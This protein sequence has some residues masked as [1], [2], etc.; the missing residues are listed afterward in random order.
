MIGPFPLRVHSSA[1]SAA[2][3]TAMEREPRI[4]AGRQMDV[5]IA[6]VVAKHDVVSRL[7]RL[8]QLRFQQQRLGFG[9][10]DRRLDASDLRDHRGEARV[11]LRLEEIIADALPEIAR[12]ADVEQLVVRAEHAVDAGRAG[13]RADESLAVEG[14]LGL[15]TG[16]ADIMVGR[17]RGFA[18]TRGEKGTP[19]SPRTRGPSDF[20]FCVVWEE[21][22]AASP[23]SRGRR[24]SRASPAPSP[25]RRRSSLADADVLRGPVRKIDPHDL[26][27][28]P[29]RDPERTRRER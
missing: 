12:L 27:Q 19:S 3:R 9:A 5:R 8:D 25:G 1:T 26:V 13:Q 10:R 11:H 16:H 21:E 24:K 18:R 17:A 22:G 28:I 7:Q 15:G 14:G 23:R 4:V 29:V 6:L 2:P 20:A